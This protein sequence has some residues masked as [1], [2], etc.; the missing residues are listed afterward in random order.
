MLSV[1]QAALYRERRSYYTIPLRDKQ[2][3]RAKTRESAFGASQ[4][5]L[6]SC[7]GEGWRVP[8][9]LD[10]SR[11]QRSLRL[12]ESGEVAHGEPLEEVDDAACELGHADQFSI[13]NGTA[14][15]YLDTGIELRETHREQTELMEIRLL[16]VEE[17]LGMTREGKATDGPSALALLWC[18]PLLLE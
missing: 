7:T 2:A 3:E 16:L 14:Y 10:Q 15:V 5:D 18:E 6:V 17:A 13:S 9:R 12:N 8:P 1:R 4:R 11:T